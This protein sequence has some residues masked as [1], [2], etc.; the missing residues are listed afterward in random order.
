MDKFECIQAF[1]R[2]AETHSFVEAARQLNVT[3]S[4]IT[5]RVKKL[6]SYIQSPLFHRST[7]AFTLSEAGANFFE[8]CADLVS[9]VDSALE[10]MRVMKTTPTGVLTTSRMT[11]PRTLTSTS[12]KTSK[13]TPRRPSS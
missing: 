4:V 1:V 11:R 2:V 7:R 3:P 6:E 12:G 5:S 9:H 13:T 10:R 8:E